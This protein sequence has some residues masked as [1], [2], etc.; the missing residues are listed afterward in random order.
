MDMCMV[1]V[2]VRASWLFN[3]WYL[4]L[5]DCPAFFSPIINRHRL[6]TKIAFYFANSLH[7]YNQ[8]FP[9][10]FF[11]FGFGFFPI[12]LVPSVVFYLTLRIIFFWYCYC[13]HA[14]QIQSPFLLCFHFVAQ[15]QYRIDPK[16]SF[17]SSV[18][19]F[20]SIYQRVWSVSGYRTLRSIDTKIVHS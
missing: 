4:S 16:V 18:R 11:G 17:S 8:Y 6:H 12:P 9:F 7:M 20:R 14:T 1:T 3:S 5:F 19:F 15:F 10:P 13:L 2:C